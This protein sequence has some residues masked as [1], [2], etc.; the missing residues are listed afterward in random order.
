[1]VRQ[2][3]GFG[4]AS[5]IEQ[6]LYGTRGTHALLSITLAERRVVVLVAPWSHSAEVTEAVFDD[7]EVRH[8]WA[9]PDAPPEEARLPW[10]VIGFESTEL[11]GGRWEFVVN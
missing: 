5:A 10:D 3:E 6:H 4:V 11:T 7:A 2:P 9:A 8:V 1:M